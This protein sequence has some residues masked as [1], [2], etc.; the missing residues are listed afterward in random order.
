MGE[1]YA[2]LR[3][4]DGA[5]RCIGTAGTVI[6][7]TAARWDGPG[8]HSIRFSGEMALATR[9]SN[10]PICMISLTGNLVNPKVGPTWGD[11]QALPDWLQNHRPTES[12]VSSGESIESAMVAV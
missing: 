3:Q 6:E 5:L 8:V 4:F 1:V 7:T 12:N 10:M 11:L 2:T 9:T